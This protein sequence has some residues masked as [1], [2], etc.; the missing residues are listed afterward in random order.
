MLFMMV[1]YHRVRLKANNNTNGDHYEGFGYITSIEECL[2]DE[3][4]NIST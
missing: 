2:I 3:Y 4:D 1:S